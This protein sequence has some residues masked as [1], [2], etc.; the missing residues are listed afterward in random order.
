MAPR[1]ALSAFLLIAAGCT[2]TEAPSVTTIDGA[3]FLS[4]RCVQETPDGLRG[5]PLLG[6][7]CSTVEEVEGE[8]ILRRMG[9]VECRCEAVRTQPDGSRALGLVRAVKAACTPVVDERACVVDWTDCQQTPGAGV[10][11][12]WIPADQGEIPLRFL[13]GAFLLDD[14]CTQAPP[15][16][17][18]VACVPAGQGQLRGYVGS[19][20]TGRVTVLDLTAGEDADS[21]VDPKRILDVDRSIPGITAVFV[22]DLISDVISH[23]L[24]DF[25]ATVNSTTG[26]LTVIPDESHVAGNL[27]VELGVAPLLA[28]VTWPSVDAVA[29]DFGRPPMAWIAAPN[30]GLVL[31]V[32]L[33]RLQDSTAEDVLG[34]PIAVTGPDGAVAAPGKLA[35]SPDGRTLFVG[36]ARAPLISVIALDP[37][38]GAAAETGWIALSGAD[39]CSD[40]YLVR[41]VDPVDDTS[42]VNGVDDDGDGLVDRADPDCADAVGSEA[43]VPG[44]PKRPECADGAD[45]DGDGLVDGEDP[46]CAAEGCGDPAA[47][48]LAVDWE[49]PPPACADGV[50]NDGDGRVDRADPDCRSEA[51]D[52]ESS[53]AGAEIG[54]CVLAATVCVGANP[55]SWCAEAGARC[56]LPSCGDGDDN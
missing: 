55:P 1:I 35:V 16:R 47:C 25:V 22:D 53:A 45:N 38:T 36:H 52:D 34:E 54:R 56:A 17:P 33:D 37:T 20:S 13:D 46:D 42:C 31:P 11:G 27:R 41:R 24:G 14:V 7:G 15:A 50:D 21:D 2:A 12:D 3:Q 10:G 43:A 8:R 9:S 23:P 4:L 18:Q 28:A 39:A 40:G 26:S 49:R 32:H 48:A 44:C 6:C 19:G 29:P 30:A 51:D 5:L